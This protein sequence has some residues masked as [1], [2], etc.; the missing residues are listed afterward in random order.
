MV[1]GYGGGGGADEK[2]VS[3]EE[4]GVGDVTDIGEVEKVVI[5]ADLDVGLAVAVGSEHAGDELGVTFAK[6]ACWA[7]GGGEESVIVLTIGFDDDVFSP[8]L[9]R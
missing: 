3:S 9:E 7:D 8:G 2:A 6:D 1:E 4:V 5:V